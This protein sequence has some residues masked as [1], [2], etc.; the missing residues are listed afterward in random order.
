MYRLLSYV[1]TTQNKCRVRYTYASSKKSCCA[2]TEL[3]VLR[4]QVF[5]ISVV[6]VIVIIMIVFQHLTRPQRQELKRVSGH[7]PLILVQSI[8]LLFVSGLAVGPA[9]HGAEFFAGEKA[10]I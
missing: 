1:I 4:V 5:V 8:A 3:V 6:V 7:V 2:I 10:V 9:I